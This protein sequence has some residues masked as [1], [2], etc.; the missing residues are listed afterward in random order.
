[1][2]YRVTLQ[3]SDLFTEAQQ[4]AHESVSSRHFSHTVNN[5]TG[6]GPIYY[7]RMLQMSLSHW[8]LTRVLNR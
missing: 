6:H 7:C 1:M 3:Q 8:Q 5:L 2:V 4:C